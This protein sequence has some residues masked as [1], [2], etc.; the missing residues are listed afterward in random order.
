MLSLYTVVS[1]NF[2]RF[3]LQ[4][5][6]NASFFISLEQG[7]VPHSC[8]NITNKELADARPEA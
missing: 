4:D 2:L 6:H 3:Q 8:A 1:E 5:Q 7:D